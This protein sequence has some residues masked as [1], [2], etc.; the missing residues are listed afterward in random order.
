MTC[1]LAASTEV[2]PT[3]PDRCPR[4]RRLEPPGQ[5]LEEILT[6]CLSS[7]S[8]TRPSIAVGYTSLDLECTFPGHDRHSLRNDGLHCQ[9]YDHRR[10]QRASV[11]DHVQPQQFQLPPL[12]QQLQ[13]Q[14]LY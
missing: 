12:R 3:K 9:N 4:P 10:C 13:Q 2:F 11:V 8:S 6:G 7:L 5:D 14:V 1:S